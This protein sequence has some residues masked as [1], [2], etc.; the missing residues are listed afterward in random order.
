MMASSRTS[1][2]RMKSRGE[3]GQPCF[4]PFPKWIFAGVTPRK[5][6]RAV[7]SVRR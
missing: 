2:T 5:V 7:R 6:V 4:T 3:R 1:I